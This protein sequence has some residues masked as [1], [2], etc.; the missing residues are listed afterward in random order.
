[1]YICLKILVYCPKRWTKVLVKSTKPGI[2][3]EFFQNEWWKILD[4]SFFHF[5]YV[6]QLVKK[7]SIASFLLL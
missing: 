2:D 3:F 7:I 4:G 5:L 1:M 6:V